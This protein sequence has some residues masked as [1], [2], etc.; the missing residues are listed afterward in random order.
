VKPT[1][2]SGSLFSADRGFDEKIASRPELLA[3]FAA[4]YEKG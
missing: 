4:V 2:V 3:A 1:P